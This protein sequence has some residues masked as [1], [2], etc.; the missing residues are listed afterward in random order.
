M[1]E[2]IRDGVAAVCALGKHPDLFENNN[3]YSIV[4]HL[5]G[6]KVTLMAATKFDKENIIRVIALD[7]VN[8]MDP[9]FTTSLPAINLGDVS[10][11]ITSGNV[12]GGV[13]RP[14]LADGMRRGSGRHSRTSSR[15][16]TM[17]SS[18]WTQTPITCR[19]SYL[20]ETNDASMEMRA[21][22]H[23]LIRELFGSKNVCQKKAQ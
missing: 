23:A 22:V 21:E 15:T 3:G 8:E 9:Q 20:D 19:M 10:A 1:V 18:Y 14:L 4:G 7:P 12:A 16:T 2:H 17:P 13:L 11:C 6:G 5:L